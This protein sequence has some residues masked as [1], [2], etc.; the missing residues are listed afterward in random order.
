M[1]RTYVDDR[2]KKVRDKRW[3]LRCDVGSAGDSTRGRCPTVSDPSLDPPELWQF[4]AQGWFISAV[5]GDICPPCL[6]E[7]IAPRGDPAARAH[8]PTELVSPR[9]ATTEH[10]GALV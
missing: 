8:F 5:F 9:A 10:D 2:K 4:A 6:A 3:V 7:G 1:T